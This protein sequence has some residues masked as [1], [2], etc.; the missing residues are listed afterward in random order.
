MHL[1]FLYSAQISLKNPRLLLK[2][3]RFKTETNR[4]LV[5]PIFLRFR[6]L[7]CFTLIF[8]Q[9]ISI[10]SFALIGCCT[11]L[12]RF[13]LYDAQSKKAILD[14]KSTS[15]E[16]NPMCSLLMFVLQESL[17][18]LHKCLSDTKKLKQC[19]KDFHTD[20]NPPPAA[21]STSSY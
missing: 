13:Q 3:T 19:F 7:T 21:V 6:Q 20:L 15:I 8:H 9:R 14:Q 10:S 2:P 16:V 11:R 17:T 18:K 5:T 4:D 12:L 1:V